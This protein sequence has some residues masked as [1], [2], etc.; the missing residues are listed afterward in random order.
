MLELICEA[1]G[2]SI[3]E[4][5]VKTGFPPPTVHRIL[6]TLVERGYVRQNPENK[7]Y[8]LSSQFLYYSDRVQQQFDLIPMA[9]PLLE[10][11]SRDTEASANL[12][13]MDNL[14]VVYVDHVHSQKHILRT[15]TRLGAREPLYATGVGKIFMSRMTP[16]DLEKYLAKTKMKR[17]TEHTIGNRKEMIAEIERIRRQGY[18]VDEQ[19][20]SMGVR[21]IAA[22]V[23]NRS[24]KVIAAISI[25]GP[26]QFIP[27]EEV[28]SLSQRVMESAANLSEELGYKQNE[29]SNNE[30]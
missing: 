13:V 25:S 1:N 24:G 30:R 7:N 16:A 12:C 17:F 11:L 15:F 23:H 6:N 18:A 10:Q 21:C 3:H 26:V 27:I 14:V 9:R 28:E 5:S 4:L 22:P 8:M 20:R 2:I 29:K 19:E